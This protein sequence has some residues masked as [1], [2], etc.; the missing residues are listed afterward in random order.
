MGVAL[1]DTSS[2]TTMAPITTTANS[3]NTRP[4]MPP[5]NRMG[6]KAAIR[7]RLMD[8]SVN[9]I[10][11]VPSRAACGAVLPRS[12]WRRML[13]RTTMASSTMKPVDTVKAISEML[14]MLRPS[15]YITQKVPATATG[16]TTLGMAAARRLRMKA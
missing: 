8:T 9:Q 1:R 6:M 14:L 16:T 5:M 2:D 12:R 15:A 13:S 7:A 4:T 3:R 10:S 11:R